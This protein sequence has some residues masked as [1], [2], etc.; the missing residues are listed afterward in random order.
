[1]DNL[2]CNGDVNATVK[3][4]F[5]ISN[6]VNNIDNLNDLYAS[7]HISLKKILNLENFAVALYH[8]EKD[9]MTFPYFVDELDDELGEVFEISKKQSLTA[10]VINAGEPMMF[11]E[12]DIEQMD[13]RAGRIAHHSACKVWAGAPLKIKG[14]TFG[15]ILV[16]SYLSRDAVKKSDLALLNSVAEFIAVSIERKQTQIARDESERINRVLSS[17]TNAVHA[18]ENLSQLYG[19]IHDALSSLMDVSNFYIALYDHAKCTVR[20][21]YFIDQFDEALNR[22]ET[23][24]EPNSLTAEV[25][26]EKRPLLLKEKM[27]LERASQNKVVGTV[28]RIWLG[29]PLIIKDEVIGVVAV[30]SYTD[31]DLYTD[32]D[33]QILSVVSGQMALAIHRKRAEDALRE[34]EARYRLLADSLSDVV[35]TRDM[36]L[37]LTYISPSVE[38]QTG[39]SVEEKMVQPLEESLPPHSLAK[40]TRILDEEIKREKQGNANPSRS[41]AVQLESYRKDGTVYPMES[42]ISFMRD[43]MGKAIAI[44]GINR[45][46][47]EH[48]RI[49]DELRVRDEKLSYLSK[50]TEQLSLAAASMISM[51][52][53][54]QFFNTISNAI[55]NHSDFER[56]LISLFKEERPFRD[57]IAYGG[58]ESDVVDRLRDVEMPKEWYDSVF[59]E[60]NKIGQFSY[61][62]PHT[63]KHILK[64]DATVYGSGP[65]LDSEDNW[66][67][68][69]NLFVRM[70][71]ENNETIGVIS[72]DQSKSGL[73]PS[74][75]TVRPLEVF[76]SL[77][78]QIVILKKEQEE[79]RK[80]EMWATEQRLTSMVEKSPL[81]VIECNLDS[82]I[83]NWNLSA[84]QMFGF[85]AQESMGRNLARLLVQ[86]EKRSA[87]SQ[88]WSE[89]IEQKGGTHFISDNVTKDGRVITCEWHNTPLVNAD[90]EISG[91]FCVI[92]DI[93]ERKLAE[94]EIM[95]QKANLEQLFEASPEAIALI[96]ENDQVVRIN[97]R[98]TSTF[99]F[100][101]GEVVGRSLDY[102]IIPQS[103]REESIALKKEI[104][105]G[106]HIFHETTRQR[107]DG[108]TVDVSI[109]GMP[110]TIQGKDAGI[111]VIYRDI[112]SR[113]LAELELKMAK[114][115]AE[116]A[117]QAK[118]DFLANMSH[119]IRTPMNAIIGLSHLTLNT[120]L[121]PRQHDYLTKIHYSA[122]SLLRIINDIL[123][124]SKIEAGK[125]DLESAE[126]DLDEVLDHLANTLSVRAREKE[127]L[128]LLFATSAD[129][130][131]CLIG[132]PLRL[133]QVLTNLA[134]NALKFTEKGEIVISTELV[135]AEAA[136]VTLRF[137]VRDTGIG[138]TGA[139]IDNLFQAFSQADSSTTRQYGGTGLGLTIC[140]NL[141]DLMGGRIVAESAPGEGSSFSFEVGFGRGR[142]EER[143]ILEP[144]PDLRGMK[145]LVVDDN[146]T[147]RE[148]IR[149]M[150][151]S[152]K[153]RVDEAVSG[154]DALQ[155]VESAGDQPYDLLIMD[156]RMPGIN[157]LQTSKQILTLPGLNKKPVVIMATSQGRAEAFG[158]QELVELDGFLMKPFSPSSLF[159]EIMK[160]FGQE[161][162]AS[163][164]PARGNA[165]LELSA[166]IGARILLV[167]DNYLNQ[168]VARDILESAG[169]LVTIANDGREAVDMVNSA[170]FDAVLM[171]IQMPVMDGYQAAR[172]IRSQERFQKLP[173]IA[174]TAHAM[175]GDRERSFAAGMNDHLPKPINPKHLLVKLHKWIEPPEG[176]VPEEV[177]KRMKKYEPDESVSGLYG[178]EGISAVVGLS[179]LG[180]KQGFYL[181]LLA[182]F[183]QDYAQSGRQLAEAVD[184]AEYDL[185]ERQAHSIKSVAGNLGALELQTAAADLE[186]A[187]AQGRIDNLSGML[188]EF[189][190]QLEVVLESIR[191]LA[192]VGGAASPEGPAASPGDPADLL[193]KLLELESFVIQREAKPAK[194]LIKEIAAQSWKKEY[195][196]AIFDL[197]KLIAKYK[198]Q[199]AQ[200]I[201]TTTIR[202][203]KGN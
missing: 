199:K 19:Y 100:K 124:F 109:T 175:T 64:Q 195:R 166:I 95:V 40:I 112:T 117:A 181:E 176:P 88:A 158:G 182:K 102:S 114:E 24:V 82:D 139:Q 189:E 151:E 171:D 140:K 165:G 150:L 154:E 145:V 37:N 17:I 1:M 22:T 76:S 135:E 186:T 53:E 196:Q 108:S 110:I 55:V 105:K 69:D 178:M 27:I 7:I 4:L 123:D 74:P 190:K 70:F 160:A 9:S 146:P 30:Q 86:K 8:E 38:I 161:P 148:I 157:G 83:I 79:R 62:I 13:D 137:T 163:H 116:E 23:L 25:I 94:Q 34:S 63:K 149:S 185:A 180:G 16:Q 54:R 179:R 46:I 203:L 35:W 99:G 172:K 104:Q 187:L 18:T 122:Q 65:V 113:K 93:T 15:A 188:G 73:R 45:D 200:D 50:Q 20:F 56:V 106:E 152:F 66:H 57:I 71:D 21:E 91:V 134:D 131:R 143:H 118:S 60:E 147:A 31:A 89:I 84:E 173:I 121:N 138:M 5:E 156:W 68:E 26:I 96:N 28:P 47:T 87:F 14:R 3:V 58:M 43:P 6:A 128:E 136:R 78:S 52:D 167:E 133:G 169:L 10:K 132:D 12:E 80:A 144:A 85:R 193:E 184:R 198:F 33:L 183:L 126:F 29:A 191:G 11:Y 129:A 125:L 77:I 141:V 115:Y 162:H 39:F 92:Q 107:K 44:V 98:F 67:P 2:N 170:E 201:L 32:K 103:H 49:E 202:T 41:R 72:V 36:D 101:P 111:Y 81:A 119:E 120:G 142:E 174:M 130:P 51:K 177:F 155:K 75:D 48:K 164:R 127:D 90:K 159:N 197:G 42:V 168:Q 192:P 153:F 59:I 97:S 194:K 61:Y